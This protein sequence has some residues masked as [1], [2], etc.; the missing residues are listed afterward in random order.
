MAVGKM[1]RQCFPCVY[2]TERLVRQ[3]SCTIPQELATIT[4]QKGKGE[5][6]VKWGEGGGGGDKRKGSDGGNGK[7]WRGVYAL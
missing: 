6:K 3:P 7:W 2:S 1:L 5:E 4:K